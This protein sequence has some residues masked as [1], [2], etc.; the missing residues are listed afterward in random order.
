MTM[1]NENLDLFAKSV[2]ADPER[3]RRGLRE[4][5]RNDLRRREMEH[6]DFEDSAMPKS[7][8]FLI[9]IPRI[10]EKS[11]RNSER[12][13]AMLPEATRTVRRLK[14]MLTMAQET[15]SMVSEPINILEDGPE[16]EVVDLTGEEA[17]RFFPRSS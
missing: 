5:V 2:G 1:S 15:L 14:A 8:T 12:R 7:T 3:M 13:R 9:R 17:R 16:N 11:A 10:S 4:M 6:E